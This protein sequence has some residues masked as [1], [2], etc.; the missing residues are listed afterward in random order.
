MRRWWYAVRVNGLT[1]LAVTKL[2]VLD[3][4][5]DIPV[6]TAYRLDG[7]TCEQIPAMADALG[8]L[9]PV[10]GCIPDGGSPRRRAA[11]GRAAQ[12]ARAYP[13]G[14]RR[15]PRRRSAT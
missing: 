3:S 6:C 9:Q 8:R 14:S 11:P 2:D 15:C 4:F 10:Y 1:G 12:S 7:E 5:A 13:S